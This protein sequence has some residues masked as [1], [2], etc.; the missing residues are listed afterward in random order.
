M[1]DRTEA[2]D[3]S[4][5]VELLSKLLMDKDIVS[6]VI[7][8]SGMK[9]RLKLVVGE[10]EAKCYNGV[11]SVDSLGELMLVNSRKVAL[12]I[13]EID[14][15]AFK[16]LLGKTYED[17]KP[18]TDFD[19]EFDYRKRFVARIKPEITAQLYIKYIEFQKEANYPA[20]GSKEKVENF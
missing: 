3:D 10:P 8:I 12:A 17:Y 15:E 5:V 14:G 20:A 16:D 9:F 13:V 1:N 6:D 2:K 4:K 19:Y 18:S 11:K 7:E